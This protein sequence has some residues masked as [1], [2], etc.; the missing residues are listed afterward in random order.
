MSLGAVRRVVRETFTGTVEWADTD[1]GGHHHNSF[2]L[3]TVEAAEARLFRR[4]G[5]DDCL[6]TS[7]RVRQEVDYLT[8][9][10]FGQD[11]TVL[12]EIRHIGRTSM[13]FHFELW[14]E[15]FD[16][17]PS[18]PVPRRLAARGR[19]ISVHVPHGGV[20]SAPWPEN[21]RKVLEAA[22]IEA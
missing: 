20:A 8:K 5:L 16:R 17:A 2:V 15:S 6:P 1:A 12:L 9:L 11:V 18:G 4:L 13:T 21:V 22:S 3:R 14:G 10:Y 19:V 7:P